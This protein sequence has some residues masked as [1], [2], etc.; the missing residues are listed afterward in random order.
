MSGSLSSLPLSALP[1]PGPHVDEEAGEPERPCGAP[2][3]WERDARSGLRVL[4][5]SERC[6][7]YRYEN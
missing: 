3:V 1:C 6:G 5:C 2:T 4:R 7:F